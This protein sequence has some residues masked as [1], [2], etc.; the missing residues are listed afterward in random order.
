MD[1][2][3]L[4]QCN[5]IDVKKDIKYD[6]LFIQ[7]KKLLI[8]SLFIIIIIYLM[9]L[10][11]DLKFFHNNM[12]L[13]NIYY[14]EEE[15]TNNI[16]FDYINYE[17]SIITNKII[18]NA[19]W[20]L[21]LDEAYFINGII[22]KFKPKK[23]LEI[24]VANGGSSI[25]ILNAIKDINDSFLVSMDLNTQMYLNSE[26]KTGYRVKKYFPELSQKWRLFTGDMPHK[27]LV[28]LN[29]TFDFLF[30][31]TAHLAPGEILNLIEVLP[32]LK[33]KAILILHDILWHLL[34]NVKIYPSNIYLFSNIR[35][36]KILLNKNGIGNVGGI[37]LH[38]NQDKYYINYFL[39]LLCNWEYIP[40][41]RHI[42]DMKSFIQK[43]Y[44]NSIYVQIFEDAVT[45]NQ[46]SIKRQ[47]NSSV[48]FNNE[49]HKF[50]MKTIGNNAKN[51]TI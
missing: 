42:K 36:D 30:L 7:I 50:Y 20:Q 19:G 48:N 37:F 12:D 11:S 6:N 9:L 45:M 32:F 39:L 10:S 16:N 47:L 1:G 34:T 28:K 46:I 33:E 8:I 40:I 49:R 38:P 17:K 51:M 26:L 4:I 41:D 13:K 14:T 24:G 29:E 27:F 22:R 31:D 3:Q 25:L 44:N 5:I 23:C 35:G 21:I 18:K 2:K 15:K 43:Y